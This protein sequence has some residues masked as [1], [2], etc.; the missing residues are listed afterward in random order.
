MDKL[1]PF[2]AFDGAVPLR[3]A[4]DGRYILRLEPSVPLAFH[5]AQPT[6]YVLMPNAGCTVMLRDECQQ[7]LDCR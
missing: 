4:V 7:T 5:C 3:L 2:Q 6:R 1:F